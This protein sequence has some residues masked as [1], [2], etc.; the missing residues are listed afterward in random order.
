MRGRGL[1]DLEPERAGLHPRRLRHDVDLDAAHA[2]RGDQDRVLER[3]DRRGVVARALRRD[4]EPGG[5]RVAHDRQHVG[6]VGGERD[7]RGALVDGEVPGAP[8]QVPLGL[9][10]GDDLAAD[11]GEGFEDLG[12]EHATMLP[13][14]PPPGIGGIPTPPLSA[15]VTAARAN[16]NTGIEEEAGPTGASRHSASPAGRVAANARVAPVS[17]HARARPGR[18]ARKRRPAEDAA[19]TRPASSMPPLTLAGAAVT[20]VADRYRDRRRA[21][22]ARRRDLEV[23]AHLQVDAAGREQVRGVLDRLA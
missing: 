16:V 7:E 13:A 20:R 10:G 4:L 3:R 5:P 21:R 8:R 14:R 23:A 22:A 15:G 12:R 18:V 2:L 6:G 19:P 11:G 9:V 1:G 17:D